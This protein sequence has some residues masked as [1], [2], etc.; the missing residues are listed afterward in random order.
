V[1]PSTEEITQSYRSGLEKSE[2]GHYK[3]SLQDKADERFR[4]SYDKEPERY[5]TD[6]LKNSYDS[7]DDRYHKNYNDKLGK[8]DRYSRSTL[9]KEQR[10]KTMLTERKEDTY[11]LEK[12]DRFRSSVDKDLDT[13]RF[14]SSLDRNTGSS[15]YKSSR[16]QDEPK[17]RYEQ[18]E[19]LA[20]HDL[21][22]SKPDRSYV[23]RYDKEMLER[24]RS[25][26][27]YRSRPEG[28]T[29]SGD[30]KDTSLTR[31]D[32]QDQQ[33]YHRS[34]DRSKSE[35]VGRDRNLKDTYSVEGQGLGSNREYKTL[36]ASYTELL[37]V[38]QK[39]SLGDKRGW[40]HIDLEL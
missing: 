11:S 30:T 16:D 8:E 37:R 10:N 14:R 39:S 35:S 28:V 29:V 18:S 12:G 20:Q 23:D 32:L 26:D 27:H 9:E 6:R 4:S 34:Y 2:R 33:G 36:T 31:Y 22:R 5:R 25:S 1:A 24:S 21:E 17:Y 3:S 13:M 40:Y 38:T 7:K 19:R 15:A